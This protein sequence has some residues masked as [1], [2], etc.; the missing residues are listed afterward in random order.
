M[1]DIIWPHLRKII[2]VYSH[3]M[4]EHL[5]HL[6]L[7]L[8]VLRAHQ[9]FVKKIKCKFGCAEFNYLGHLI[10]TKGVKADGKKLIAMVE[11]P[12]PKSLKALWGFLRLTRYYLKFVKGYGSIAAPLTDLLKKNAFH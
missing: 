5:Q 7:S 4:Q 3:N 10:S 8:D 1:N 2:L 12:R 11:W 9:L 6:N